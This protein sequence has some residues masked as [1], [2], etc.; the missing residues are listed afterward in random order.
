MKGTVDLE[1]VKYK[2]SE[3]EKKQLDPIFQE[4][5]MTKE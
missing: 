2:L 5:L 1:Q 3:L 4:D